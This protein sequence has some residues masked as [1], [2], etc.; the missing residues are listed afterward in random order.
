MEQKFKAGDVVKVRSGSEQMTVIEYHVEYA[1]AVF[2]AFDRSGQKKFPNAVVTDDV[3]CEWM[4]K[5]E[6][7]RGQFKESSLDLVKQLEE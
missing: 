7:K 4:Y 5:G 2:N 1:G 6:R 3:L